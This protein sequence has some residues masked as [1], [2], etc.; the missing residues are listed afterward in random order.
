MRRELVE[1]AVPRFKLTSR[2]S[3]KETLE[4]LGMARAFERHADNFLGI[5]DETP[6]WLIDVVHKAYV[7][8]NEQGTEAA[9]ATA[10]GM[11][12]GIPPEPPKFIADHPFVFLIRDNLSGAIL[13]FG[14]VVDPR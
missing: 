14:R 11:A 9:A 4:G 8:V 13:F 10:V 6:Q 2:F 12:G 5:T 1:I 7:D 3:L